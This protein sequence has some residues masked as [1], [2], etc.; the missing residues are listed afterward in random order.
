MGVHKA[1]IVSGKWRSQPACFGPTGDSKPAESAISRAQWM[2]YAH[3]REDPKNA[4]VTPLVAEGRNGTPRQGLG[5]PI[6]SPN[7]AQ[8]LY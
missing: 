8:A 1:F 3:L 5:T 7:R 2:P 6:A 4:S